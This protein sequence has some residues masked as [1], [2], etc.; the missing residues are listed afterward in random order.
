LA[1]EVAS[2]QRFGQGGRFELQPLERRLLVDGEPATL[3]ARAFD[4]LLE[5]AS[6]PGALRTK[7]E[8][9]EAVWPGVVVEEGNLATQISTLRKIL[10]GDVIATIP[11]R[12]YRFAAQVTAQVTAVGAGG[13]G[14]TRL[15]QTFLH[16]RRQALRHGVC[17]VDLALVSDPALVPAAVIA[18]LGLGGGSGDPLESLCGLCTP[19]QML[20]AL[21]NAEHLLEATAQ[22]AQALVEAAPGVRLLV[23][24]QAPLKVAA[25]CVYRLGALAVPPGP[26][27]LAE[28]LTFG[29]VQLFADRAQAVDS[30][31]S[32]TDAGCRQ[33]SRF[34][35]SSTGCRWPS[36]WP[37]RARPCSACTSSP[38]RWASGSS[39]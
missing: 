18:A 25:E 36:S 10:G 26:L 3:G 15:A 14:K 28:A 4:L 11:G 24:S 8:L 19:L 22:A 30:R 27:P 12:G 1:V 13:V 2:P 29:A 39:C 23:T 21:D 31:L 17:F 37:P 34:A 20:V 35:A 32:L 9:I 6:R 16:E 33:S 38:R 5:L 7:H